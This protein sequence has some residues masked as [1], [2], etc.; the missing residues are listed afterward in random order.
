M[1]RNSDFTK[2]GLFLTEEVCWKTRETVSSQLLSD[3]EKIEKIITENI[4]CLNNTLLIKNYPY[5]NT[6]NG[7]L[8]FGVQLNL[9]SLIYSSSVL[10][11]NELE[12]D[13]VKYSQ[14]FTEYF[15]NSPYNFPYK[16]IST[17][18]FE[19]SEIKEILEKFS[20]A[21]KYPPLVFLQFGN[22]LKKELKDVKKP[23]NTALIMLAGNDLY[24]LKSASKLFRKEDNSYKEYFYQQN[25][26]CPAFNK[27][28]SLEEIKLLNDDAHRVIFD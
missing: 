20:E 22:N 24:E 7:T 3:K 26:D 27:I 8:T 15:Y 12:N 1:K 28:L 23:D 17:F 13:K 5:C 10:T 4:E 16:L 18:H 6:Y 21:A 19:K 2:K 14:Y 25:E 9:N 11:L